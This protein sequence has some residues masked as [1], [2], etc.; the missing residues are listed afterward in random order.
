M[1]G[2]NL[3]LMVVDNH[4]SLTPYRRIFEWLMLD[5]I[6]YSGTCSVL[7]LAA[8]FCTV[9]AFSISGRSPSTPVNV[10]PKPKFKKNKYTQVTRSPIGQAESHNIVLTL[11][12]R[13]SWPNALY[14][15]FY[16]FDIKEKIL[17][18]FLDTQN[19]THF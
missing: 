11:L 17:F 6:M 1:H 9:E 13:D 19:M 15:M 8:A 12:L 5:Y 16:L 10:I 18:G 2:I 4:L 3:K 7:V 14:Y